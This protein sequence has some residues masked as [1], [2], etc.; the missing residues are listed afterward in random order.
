MSLRRKG[1]L[2]LVA[3]LLAIALVCVWRTKADPSRVSLFVT[4]IIGAVTTVYALF[5]Y[6]M[7]LANQAMARAAVESS[8]LMERSLRFSH[9]PN[10]LYQTINT[11]DPTFQS[12]AGVLAPIDN[13]DYKR[14]LAEFGGGGQ[15]KEFVFAVVQNKGQGAA[16][17]LHIDAA[18]NVT[19]SSSPNR[20][21]SVAKQGSVQILEA[22]KAVAL[23]V[24]ISKVPTPDDRVALVSARLTASDFYR[25]AIH[26]P[27]QQIDVDIQ[28]HHTEVES[29]CVV[30][31]L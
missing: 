13:D 16:T 18:Y 8:T 27:E 23:C 20:D 7:L 24:F 3:I 10:L 30:R 15:Q 19:D 22:G 5:T 21:S 2:L 6:E 29:G 25:D 26:E 12:R 31:L 1:R 14:A 9:T 17:G 28:R 11:K 4:A